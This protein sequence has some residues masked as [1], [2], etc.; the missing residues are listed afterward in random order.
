MAN[1]P[2]AETAALRLSAFSDS[3]N[4]PLTNRRNG[5]S[6]G[7]FT[8]A[9][10]R[11]R[12][13]WEVT[14][15]LELNVIADYEKDHGGN[16]VWTS[17]NA[18]AQTPILKG[19]GVTP[20][21]GNTDLCIDGG[22]SKK[23]ETYGLSIQADWTLGDY[24]LTSITADR[25]F[26]RYTNN[27]SDT[28]PANLL[29][30]NEAIDFSNQFSQELRIASPVGERFEYVGG[31]YYYNYD[32]KAY[33][34]QAGQLGVPILAQ[35][36]VQANRTNLVEVQQFSYAAFGQGTFHL[37]DKWSLIA[38]GRGTFD[39]MK[40]SNTFGV[41]PSVGIFVP[42]F[43]NPIGRRPTIRVDTEN[44][45]YRVGA[46]YKPT[47]DTLFYLTYARGYKGPSTNTG[48]AAGAPIVKPEIPTNLEFGVKTA[49]F[50]RRLALDLAIYNQDV[51]DFQAQF[52]QTQN[53]FTTFVFGNASHLYVK[54]AELNVTARPLAG[55][56]LNGGLIYNDATY[57]DFNVPCK[58]GSTQTCNAEGRQL[59]GAP[60]W[61]VVLSGEYERSVSEDIDGYVQL[62]AV[63][64]SRVN[65][66][67]SPDPTLQIGEYTVVD[68]RIGVR[69]KDGAWG[70]SLFA[71][72][73]FDERFPSLVFAD[74]LISSNY[75]QAYSP[76]AF[77]TIGISLEGRY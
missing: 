58:A 17:L 8:N 71:K 56:R 35:L 75:D 11:A 64:R 77:R 34:N 18:G 23:I 26:S 69:Q 52:V 25:Q 32:Y 66:S 31:L 19:C 28:L 20:G 59:S 46:Q 7:D 50:D 76:R 68:G 73:L 39:L 22:N 61:K 44:F 38:G 42:G 70:V 45:S 67:S 60:K 55:L 9:G 15:D 53:G 4:G 65:T 10:T 13:L 30:T 33:V 14:P 54:G 16:M 5:D 2:L 40:T 47:D 57:G 24:T 3:E 37:T 51:K 27:D 43:S 74:P 62:A 48:E 63:Y 41:D 36:G 72:N 6:I 12:L 49:F 29:N 1:L 21:L